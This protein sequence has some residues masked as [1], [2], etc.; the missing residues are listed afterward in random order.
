MAASLDTEDIFSMREFALIAAGR[1]PL[2]VLTTSSSAST[3]EY[4][5]PVEFTAAAGLDAPVDT[6]F[7][8]YFPQGVKLEAT[9]LPPPPA[10][11]LEPD[12]PHTFCPPIF[13]DDTVQSGYITPSIT[14]SSLYIPANE[15][16]TEHLFKQLDDKYNEQR[17]VQRPNT[18]I[19][20]VQYDVP[21]MKE[22]AKRLSDEHI[23]YLLALGKLLPETLGPILTIWDADIPTTGKRPPPPVCREEKILKTLN[24]ERH[25][26]MDALM[27][28]I[29]DVY[30]SMSMEPSVM[31]FGLCK[32][33]NDAIK[34]IHMHLS[35][36]IDAL[37]NYVHRRHDLELSAK[38]P[39]TEPSSF[40]HFKWHTGLSAKLNKSMHKPNSLK[41][42]IVPITER[43]K[44]KDP[45][46]S[47]SELL[48]ESPFKNAFRDIFTALY[49]FSGM[50]LEG[51]FYDGTA[52][53]TSDIQ[54]QMFIRPNAKTIFPR[55]RTLQ[56]TVHFLFYVPSNDVIYTEQQYLPEVAVQ[57]GKEEFDDMR[58]HRINSDQ[59]FVICYGSG[60][61]NS[62]KLSS[63]ANRYTAKGEIRDRRFEM[64][65]EGRLP[66]PGFR[67][68][69]PEVGRTPYLPYD[70]LL[71]FSFCFP[72]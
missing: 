8:D 47:I 64:C 65:L 12:L 45:P 50:S 69:T 71:V 33:E 60:I 23:R 35:A 52:D 59:M 40:L 22:E 68:Q 32:S 16:K 66:Q 63:N 14:L 55:L 30:P 51:S 4:H 20:T 38:T 29:F 2:P 57:K 36:N 42:Y 11:Q 48:D 37:V 53:V 31:I 56:N 54:C 27:K 26:Q 21:K 13:N 41:Q 7:N 9:D 10:S 6:Y 49:H 61:R 19:V 25:D 44:T 67:F 58:T 70:M 34:N 3:S 46:C 17:M 62:P 5:P 24:S 18:N 43:Y 72:H 1:S 28:F 15:V 39:H